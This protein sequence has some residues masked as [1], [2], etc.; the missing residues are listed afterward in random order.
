MVLER[1]LNPSEVPAHG[2]SLLGLLAWLHDLLSTS[3]VV[4]RNHLSRLADET[5]RFHVN[6]SLVLLLQTPFASVNIEDQSS[7]EKE[8]CPDR[9]TKLTTTHPSRLLAA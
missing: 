6:C 9:K 8:K 2:V 7:R 3:L 4:R 5:R 1:L